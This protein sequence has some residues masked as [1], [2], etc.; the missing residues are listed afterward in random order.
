MNLP[1]RAIETTG[2]I[3]EK[4]QLRLEDIRNTVLPLWASPKRNN[5]DA[6]DTADLG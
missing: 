4:R 3:D 1:V 2:V 5:D 6:K